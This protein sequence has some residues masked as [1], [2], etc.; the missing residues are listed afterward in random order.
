MMLGVVIFSIL[1]GAGTTGIGYYTPWI[2]GSSVC[3]AIGGGLLSLFRVDSPSGVWIGYQAL[4]GIG[5]GMGIQSPLIAVQTVRRCDPPLFLAKSANMTPKGPRPKRRARR[6]RNNHV[7]PNPR[8]RRRHLYHAKRLPQPARQEPRHQCPP[9][10]C[11]YRRPHRR[12]GAEECCVAE[13]H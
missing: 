11:R 2:I 4:Y 10:S 6:Y 13:V 9:I 3:M 5:V 12:D 8:R 1:S 7:L